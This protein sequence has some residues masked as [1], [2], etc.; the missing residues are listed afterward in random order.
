[1]LKC[2]LRKAVSLER[3]GR[4][5]EAIRL[6]EKIAATTSPEN[7]VLARAAVARLRASSTSFR[8]G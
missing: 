1:L 7:A 4:I 8:A 5:D 2:W 6:Y 3:R